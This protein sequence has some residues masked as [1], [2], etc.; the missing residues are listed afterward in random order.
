MFWQEPFNPQDPLLQENVIATPHIGGATERSLRGIGQAVADNVNAFRSGRM[1][2]WCVNP[3][4]A[5]T[6]GAGL[7]SP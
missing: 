5:N 2:A 7:L 6:R 1:P 4:A 3:Q